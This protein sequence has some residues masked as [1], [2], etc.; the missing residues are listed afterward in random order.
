MPNFQGLLF[1]LKQSSIRCGSFINF[2]VVAV[3]DSIIT[4]ATHAII[5][6]KI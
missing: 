5:L 4:K 6:E 3:R 1:T 2:I